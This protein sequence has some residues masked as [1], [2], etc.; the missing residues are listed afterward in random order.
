MDLVRREPELA[1]LALL[2]DRTFSDIADAGVRPRAV[3]AQAVVDRADLWDNVSP[4]GAARAATRLGRRRA[5]LARWRQIGAWVGS[6]RRRWIEDHLATLDGGRRLDPQRLLGPERPRR[7]VS[8]DYRGRPSH[9]G[10]PLSRA[11]LAHLLADYETVAAKA[12]VWVAVRGETAPGVP[13]LAA[14]LRL[15]DVPRHFPL[16]E[17]VPERA[18]AVGADLVL[19]TPEAARWA[20]GRPHQGDDV[21]RL[22]WALS[23]D[24]HGSAW[25]WG[26]S[27]R[28]FGGVG[29]DVEV[30]VEDWFWEASSWWRDRDRPSRQRRRPGRWT[31]WRAGGPGRGR[32][33]MSAALF[34]GLMIRA[35]SA[36]RV[37]RFSPRVL[38]A[39]GAAGG[40]GALALTEALVASGRGGSRARAASSVVA[41]LAARADDDAFARLVEAARD[42]DPEDAWPELGDRPRTLP[43]WPVVHEVGD[44]IVFGDLGEVRARL[45]H[46]DVVPSRVWSDGDCTPA[47][48]SL[49]VDLVDGQG[50]PAVGHLVLTD[51]R[52]GVLEVDASDL[53]LAAPIR[54]SR[55]AD[56]VRVDVPL[57]SGVCSLWAREGKW[58]VG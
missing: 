55:E 5:A 40:G 32:A 43:A 46:A 29:R 24:D 10:E 41:S 54:G 1:A 15:S 35:R 34:R 23:V 7:P 38:R 3:N 33:G 17:S 30:Q 42:V 12:G 39:V 4:F 22:A 18:R 49:S 19:R 51:P 56:G 53:D 37:G 48:T 45:R 21:G 2:M 57:A 6:E 26:P 9:W 52:G 31:Q 47:R 58:W 50:R 16:P 13:R 44:E 36:G 8:F 27:G 14:G 11:V 28:G 25:S 20:L